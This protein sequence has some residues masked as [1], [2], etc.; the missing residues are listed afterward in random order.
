M[1]TGC[2]CSGRCCCCTKPD[3]NYTDTDTAQSKPTCTDGLVAAAG[4]VVSVEQPSWVFN[5][6]H[7]GS[8]VCTHTGSQQV[9][10]RRLT[11]A[12]CACP[13]GEGGPRAA[14]QCALPERH[15]GRP[16]SCQGPGSKVRAWE[17]LPKTMERGASVS[18]WRG[19]APLPWAPLLSSG[20]H[21]HAVLVSKARALILFS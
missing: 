18:H 6:S 7:V 11:T 4:H 16:Q 2:Q 9:P 15:E 19:P 8:P 5:T 12:T 1:F 20:G 3:T 13:G 17:R 14:G 10:W 21:V